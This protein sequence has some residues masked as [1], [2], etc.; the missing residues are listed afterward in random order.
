MRDSCQHLAF[1]QNQH[2]FK[3]IFMRRRGLVGENGLGRRSAFLPQELCS[4][5]ALEIGGQRT[6]FLPPCRV[7]NQG[8]ESLQFH[9]SAQTASGDEGEIIPQ[10]ECQERCKAPYPSRLTK[11]TLSN[12][13]FSLLSSAWLSNS[14]DIHREECK[15]PFF[16]PT[17]ICFL[18]C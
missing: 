4:E 6:M 14:C 7:G 18:V 12:E 11:A 2:I 17:S 1:G 13:T 10:T 3:N 5:G 9:P 16:P 15:F 8:E